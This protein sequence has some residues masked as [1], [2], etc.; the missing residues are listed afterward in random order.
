MRRAR[1][2]RRRLAAA[3]TLL[4]VCAS[5]AALSAYGSEGGR[6]T[7]RASSGGVWRERT[8]LREQLPSNQVVSGGSLFAMVSLTNTP[9][10]GPYGLVRTTLATDKKARGPLFRLPGV[11][12]ASGRLWISGSQH[13]LPRAVEVDPASLRT[14][15]TIRFSHGY[16]AYPFV[17]VA[18]GPAGSVWLGA[19]RTLVRISVANGKTMTRTSVPAGF[20][21]ADLATDPSTTHL[22]VS[23]A[24]TVRG[25]MTGG[26]LIE[27]DASSGRRLAIA[28]SQLLSGSVAGSSLT[29]VPGGVW[30]SFRTGML[31][32][33]LHFRQSNL[34]Q[35]APPGSKV[36]L[37]PANGLFH[38]PMR[39]S[40]L[41]GGGSLWL[42]N[43]SGVRACL[44]PSTGAVR[45]RQHIPAKKCSTSSPSTR[46]DTTCTHS[47]TPPPSSKSHHPHAAGDEA[48]A[49]RPCAAS[50]AGRFRSADAGSPRPF[51]LIA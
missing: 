26:G 31:G 28:R 8:L 38:W 25:G 16:G 46:L 41:Y 36:A 47:T 10:R 45:A 30:A 24:R 13:G 2:G 5:V 49:C 15:R 43:M 14:V 39:A 48:E 22:Y 12:V 32:L 50:G 40:T 18:P 35:I 29:A 3:L 7:T 33:T 1:L 21:V 4:G 17:E 11:A 44:D 20:V 37:S 27:E 19:D 34:A 23:L 51:A 9:E 6:A 42:T